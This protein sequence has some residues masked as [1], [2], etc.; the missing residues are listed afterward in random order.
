[1]REKLFFKMIP[2][3]LHISPLSLFF[4]AAP[5]FN[6]DTL[7]KI[8]EKSLNSSS[9]NQDSLL[10]NN[11][12]E[13]QLESH[14]MKNVKEEHP[15]EEKN[16]GPK[17]KLFTKKED[18]L[19]TQAALAHHQESWN[20]IAKCVPGKTSKQCRDRWVNYLQ[21]SLKF[22]PWSNQEDKLLVSLVNMHGT[23]WTKM[24][25]H[26]PNRSTNS[27]KNR[28]YWL[29]K[30]QVSIIP[31]DKSMNSITKN[32]SDNQNLNQ[33]IFTES[34]SL[35]ENNNFI[36]HNQN[37]NF[38]NNINN[39]SNNSFSLSNQQPKNQ[40][41]YYLEKSKVKRRNRSKASKK[42]VKYIEENGNKD[43]K[44]DVIPISNNLQTN[45]AHLNEIE[46]ISF[47]PDEL[48]W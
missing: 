19:L 16:P 2:D 11:F 6:N 3:G 29:I 15:N 28:W 14:S 13:T 1:M 38:H 39:N 20:L 37:G 42:Q 41:Y 18:Q 5:S 35:I 31:A 32:F 12:E 4:S 48:D 40:K 43:E 45:V 17:R 10:P 24:K 36:F 22:E 33:H 25:K 26:F 9:V 47:N 21:P 44:N 34:N 23:H 30:N 46:F 27:I 8:D 7:L